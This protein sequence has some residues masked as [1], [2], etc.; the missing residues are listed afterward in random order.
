MQRDASSAWLGGY[1]LKRSSHVCAF[2]SSSDEEYEVLLPFIRDGFDVGAKAFHTIDPARTQDH[3]G[4]LSSADIDVS[5]SRQSGQLDFGRGTTC[6]CA[7]ASSS[8][9]RRPRCSRKRWCSQRR[10]GSRIL[11]S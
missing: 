2:F 6:I 8:L 4:R 1:E 10:K 9:A 11:G 3:L 5:G 7:A